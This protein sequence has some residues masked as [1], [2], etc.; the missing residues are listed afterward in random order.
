MAYRN[1]TPG[2]RAIH[3][4]HGGYVLVEPGATLALD[5]AKVLRVGPGIVKVA[6]PEGPGDAPASLKRLVRK[7][8]PKTKR[9]APRKR[10]TTKAKR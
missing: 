7:A 9:S 10:R 5:P 1:D 3:L 6:D 4:T 2:A 8:A